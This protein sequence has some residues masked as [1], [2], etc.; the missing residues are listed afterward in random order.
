MNGRKA[1]MRDYRDRKV[2]AGIYAVRCTATHQVW[3]GATPDL[4]TR[5]NGL[6]FTLTHGTHSDK[7][8]QAA[9]SAHGE[10]NFAFEPLEAIDDEALGPLGRA[11]LLKDRRSAWM[12]ALDARGLN[13]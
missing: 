2:E 11:S 7:A 3:V 10:A 9:W 4:S 8:L 13:R 6:W 5:R 1:L 12:V